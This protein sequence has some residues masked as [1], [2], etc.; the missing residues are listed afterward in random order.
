MKKYLFSLLLL[1]TCL[2]S[3]AFAQI[4]ES[5]DI[6]D[7]LTYSDDETLVVTDLNH[8]LMVSRRSLGSDH[9]ASY[10]IKKQ[11][12]EKGQTKLQVLH[13]MVPLWHE[14]LMRAKFK[15][16]EKTTAGV[17]RK[18]QQRG[19]LVVGLTARYIEMAYTTIKQLHSIGIDLSLNSL[20]K[21]DHE[22]EGGYAAKYIQGVIFVGLRNEKG[23]T[24]MRLLD[25]LGYTPKNV[26]FIDDKLKNIHSVQAACEKRGIPFTG[27]RYGY[28]DK[29]GRSFDPVTT[30]HELK[31]FIEQLEQERRLR[32]VDSQE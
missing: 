15:P 27:L 29:A 11:M 9:W 10:E 6:R 30:D 7:L 20:S 1:C 19:N 14:I 21:L 24:L 28:L 26:L 22:I 17:I 32:K 25:Q 2:S 31:E 3:C 4:Y 12:E 23:E 16:V 18:L 13:E 8:V 5:N